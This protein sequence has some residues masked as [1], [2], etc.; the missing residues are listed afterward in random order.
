M[1]KRTNLFL[2]TGGRLPINADC[3]QMKVLFAGMRWKTKWAIIVAEQIIEMRGLFENGVNQNLRRL[4]G[5]D[6]VAIPL[7]V[8]ALAIVNLNHAPVWAS[9]CGQNARLQFPSANWILACNEYVMKA[10]CE[11]RESSDDR[12]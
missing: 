10:F 5:E 12:D 6:P 1:S 4:L 8:C 2:L 7:G 11:S 3:A 9:C